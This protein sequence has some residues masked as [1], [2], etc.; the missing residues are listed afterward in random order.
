ML[1]LNL[2]FRDQT[3]RLF[4]HAFK[5]VVLLSVPGSP[6]KSIRL[7]EEIINEIFYIMT[8][9]DFDG[10]IYDGGVSTEFPFCDDGT[11]F[12]IVRENRRRRVSV[13]N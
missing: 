8:C 1:I 11:R 12:M 7:P 5:Y 13:H 9:C 2:R 4:F 3:A 6:G 10:H